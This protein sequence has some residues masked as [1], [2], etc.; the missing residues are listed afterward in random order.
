MQESFYEL[1]R[2]GIAFRSDADQLILVMPEAAEGED[3]F[4]E[5]LGAFHSLLKQKGVSF[6]FGISGKKSPG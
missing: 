2:D 1:A 3:Y 6:T 4:K 5:R